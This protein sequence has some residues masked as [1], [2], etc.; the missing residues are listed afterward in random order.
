MSLAENRLRNYLKSKGLKFTKVNQKQF[1]ILSGG[2][3]FGKEW[4]FGC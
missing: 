4:D 2:D 3:S 1:L